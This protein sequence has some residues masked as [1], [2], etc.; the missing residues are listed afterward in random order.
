[1]TGRTS[2]AALRG[3]M[4][5]ESRDRAR[6]LAALRMVEE[7]L[8][9]FYEP[10]EARVWLQTGH[11][12]LN[13]EKPCDLIGSDRTSEVIELIDRLGDGVYL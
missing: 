5:P 9:D 1:M 11:P 4:S 2:F 10:D 6:V 12:Q 8:S 13:G 7:R 3:A